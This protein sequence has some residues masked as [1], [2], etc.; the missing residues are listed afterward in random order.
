MSKLWHYVTVIATE[1]PE[2][3][4]QPIIVHSVGAIVL[5]TWGRRQPL[6]E[7]QMEDIQIMNESWRIIIQDGN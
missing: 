7:K 4:W 3:T 1:C 6:E 5:T 2:R